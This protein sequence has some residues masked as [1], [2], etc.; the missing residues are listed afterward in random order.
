M[1]LKLHG[2]LNTPLEDVDLLRDFGA[3]DVWKKALKHG[4][5]GVLA[6]GERGLSMQRLNASG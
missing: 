5:I 4:I 3:L 6:F 2:P 1:V